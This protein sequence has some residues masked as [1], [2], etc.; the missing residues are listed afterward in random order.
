MEIICTNVMGKGTLCI[1]TQHM[2]HRYI[3][4]YVL[5]V[6]GYYCYALWQIKEKEACAFSLISLSK[7]MAE[8]T[9]TII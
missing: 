6:V 7:S 5:F 3:T 1:P 8:T 2:Q 9:K 4:Y